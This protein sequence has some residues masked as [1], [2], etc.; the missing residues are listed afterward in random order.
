[1][2]RLPDLPLPAA[3]AA[4]LDTYQAELD[5]QGTFAERVAR[6]KQLFKTYNRKGNTTFDTI[7]NVL[8]EMCSGARRCAYCAGLSGRRSGAHL[9]EALLPRSCV[10]LAKLCVFVRAM[11]RPQGIP[12]RD[13][14]WWSRFK[15]GAREVRPRAIATTGRRSGPDR[16]T[17]RRRYRVPGTGAARHV[18]LRG[19]RACRDARVRARTLYD[20]GS[21]AQQARDLA[22]RAAR[23]LSGP[24]RA[25]TAICRRSIWRWRH[26]RARTLAARDPHP[27]APNCLVGDEASACG[28]T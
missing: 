9:P 1:M 11:Q 13:L 4:Q 24:R 8:T 10:C 16:S 5:R 3:A 19:T 22:T 12:L 20:R 25:F 26:G 27:A 23:C 18:L 2:Q 14:P 15:D 28:V 21:R 17:C 6:G 7:K